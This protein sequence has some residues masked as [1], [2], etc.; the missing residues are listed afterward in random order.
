MRLLPVLAVLVA[1]TT[2]PVVASTPPG[3][4][5]SFGEP[6]PLSTFDN[7]N[8]DAGGPARIDLVGSV[9][10][11]PVVFYSWLP[12]D[13]RSERVFQE[14]QSLTD[15]LGADHIVLYGVARLPL[16]STDTLPIRGRIQALKIHVPVLHDS[17]YVLF[18]EL[19]EEPGPYISI[20]DAQGMLRLANGVSLKQTLEYRMTVADAIRRVA[21]TGQLGTY[22]RLLRYYPA[23]EMIGKKCPD[24]EAPELTGA[25]VRRWSSMLASDR[26]NILVFWSVDCPHCRVSLPKMN[27]WLKDHPEGLNVVSAAIIGNDTT[28]TKTE[29]FCKANGFVFTTLVDQKS[30]IGTLYQVISTPTILIIRPDGVVDSVFSGEINYG[31]TFEAKKKE[32][33]K[34]T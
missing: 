22:G 1:V 12:G 17:G 13:P 6:F 3:T 20:L 14:L 25:T 19:E 26:L 33:L 4:R 5:A 10:K 31:P 8:P 32:L 7:L 18:K 9:G 24:F 34:R 30:Q 16:G 28:R 2:V 29:E 15:E 23:I 11:K 21:S 27:A